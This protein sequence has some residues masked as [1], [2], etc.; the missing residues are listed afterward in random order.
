MAPPDPASSTAPAET[1][2]TVGRLDLVLRRYAP[3][4]AL[5][6]A[7]TA[8][9]GSLYFSEVRH[10]VPCGLCWYQR[11]IMYPLA[12]ILVVGVLRGD[13]GLH[14][15]VLPF[16]LFGT[17][18]SAYHYLVQKTDLFDH[19]I[20]CQMGVPC[21]AIYIHWLGFITIPML[22][23]TAFVII[24]LA[25]SAMRT[26]AWAHRESTPWRPVVAT[27]GAVVAFFAGL[28]FFVG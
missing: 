16:S 8:M 11:V 12:V 4:L 26:G 7:W 25:A 28:Y 23:L 3:Y 9:L 18:V 20:A 17:V 1:S 24:S 2:D 5:V 27:V 13:R 14:L 15:Y 10:L 22:A 6:A 19:A 21:T